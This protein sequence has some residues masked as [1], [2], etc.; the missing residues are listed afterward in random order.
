MSKISWKGKVTNAS[1]FKTVD[2]ERRMLN[3]TWQRKHRRLG[4][5]LR[6]EVLL[7]DIIEGRMKDRA[8]HGRRRLHMLSDVATSAK[9][10]EVKR[11]AEDREGWTAKN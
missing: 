4:H 9:Y 11:A 2:E 10:L 6:N 7:R 3:T 8:Y 1:V 5:V